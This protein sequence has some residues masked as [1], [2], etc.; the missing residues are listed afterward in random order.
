MSPAA[1]D[2]RGICFC[3][4]APPWERQSPDWRFGSGPSR[5]KPLALLNRVP[6]FVQRHQIRASVH[7][8]QDGRQQQRNHAPR[9]QQKVLALKFPKFPVDA[10]LAE[11]SFHGI[12]AARYQH[13]NVPVK[14]NI[15]R[16]A[17]LLAQLAPSDSAQRRCGSHVHRS[18]LPCIARDVI[19]R[20]CIASIL[21]PA[22]IQRY[23]A[24]CLGRGVFCLCKTNGC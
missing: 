11:I 21:R 9:S 22:G 17:H 5:L 24:L 15:P 14:G 8:Q 23:T 12:T 6:H 19:T 7:H 10:G 16:G 3:L 4:H 18:L 13:P 1:A 20:S 2:D